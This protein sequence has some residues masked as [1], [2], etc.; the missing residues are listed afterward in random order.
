MVV[1][2]EV[3]QNAEPAKGRVRAFIAGVQ[4]GEAE[5]RTA[6]D[7]YVPE[8]M[9]T[10]WSQQERAGCGSPG[11]T[12]E[13]EI[14]GSIANQLVTWNG[15]AAVGVKLSSGPEGAIYKGRVRKDDA[16]P[17][18]GI[19]PIIE[20]KVCGRQLNSFRG[21]GPLYAYEV[22]VY[23]EEVHPGCGRVGVHVLLR[24]FNIDLDTGQKIE[25]GTLEGV[26]GPWRPGNSTSLG[27]AAIATEF[28]PE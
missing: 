19:E 14:N 21:A 18:L 4:C 2:G 27:D 26:A 11:V 5:T 25:L 1:I 16:A 3:W 13:F 9:L 10:V 23:P 24:A 7:A 17:G 22:L 12:V 15:G 6:P 8:V 28:M 20:G